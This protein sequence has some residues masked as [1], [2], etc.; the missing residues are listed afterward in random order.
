MHGY[1]GLDGNQVIPPIYEFGTFFRDGIAAVKLN[2][3]MRF[4]STSGETVLETDYFSAGNFSCGRA[5]FLS[6]NGKFG[7]LDMQGE[8]VIPPTFDYAYDF[9]DGYATIHVRKG[10]STGRAFID[11]N[12][13]FIHDQI[14]TNSMH[15][16]DGIASVEH[17]SGK[18][19]CINAAGE[20][21]IEPISDSYIF[22][23]E[24]LAP[25][26]IKGKIGYMDRKGEIVIP[27]R[28][29]YAGNFHDGI[30]IIIKRNKC[31]YINKLGEII[32]E[33]K[34]NDAED[35][36]EQLAPVKVGRSWGYINPEGEFEI[37][38]KYTGASCFIEGIASVHEKKNIKLMK[39][40]MEMIDLGEQYERLDY[41]SEG[42]SCVTLREKRK[43]YPITSHT[44]VVRFYAP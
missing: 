17:S 36:Y 24:G 7:Y 25:I 14:H 33:P 38:P 30:A 41:F 8:I 23:S 16:R 42:L 20:Y 21:V 10:T 3:K 29:G 32:I 31:G 22:F 2:N 44:S 6:K 5:L 39:R 34:F 18:H 37:E 11:V 9:S 19:G 26:S 40:N 12:G 15:F 1:I 28:F 13:N 35:F 27:P 43:P 4:I